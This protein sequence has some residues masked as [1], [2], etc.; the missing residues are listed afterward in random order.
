V[1]LIDEGV[2]VMWSRAHWPHR[3]SVMPIARDQSL[4]GLGTDDQSAA[5]QWG[6]ER[7][8]LFVFHGKPI[9]YKFIHGTHR[10]RITEPACN[11]HTQARQDEW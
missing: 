7:L 2:Y 5:V 1:V 10:F 3:G 9:G 8:P 4:Q 11:R 6:R